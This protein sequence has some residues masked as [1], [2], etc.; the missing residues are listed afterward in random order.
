[1]TANKP[2]RATFIAFFLAVLLGGS[3]SVAIRFSNH[4]LPPFWGASLRFVAAGII[5]WMVFFARRLS[6]PRKRDT[7]VL[8]LNGF[9]SVGASFAFLY[10]GLQKIQANLGTMIL[11]LGPLFTFFLTFFHRIESF[12]WQVLLGGLIAFG[13]MALA[14]NAQLGRNVP[15]T[16]LLAIAAGAVLSAEGNV[17]L[18]ITAPKS[19]PVTMNALSISSGAVFLLFASHIAGETLRFPISTSTWLSLTYL[20]IG[21]SV[22]MFYFFVYVLSHWTASA[23]S[24]I[25][26]LFPIV[27]TVAGA[28]LAGEM[29]TP[30]FV[31]GGLIVIAGV[32]VGAF[33][34]N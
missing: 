32:W 19:D 1:M 10:W 20:V 4:E 24:Y 18:K 26:L 5:F 29:V 3:N 33:L 6:L 16:S 27:A 2:D 8:L 31:V 22:L 9:V 12:R 17:I 30:M 23:T 15:V 21:G 25:V 14:V 13:G 28:L 11:A 34:R 7:V